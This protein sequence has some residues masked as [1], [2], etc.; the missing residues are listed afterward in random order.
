[1]PRLT[2][3]TCGASIELNPDQLVLVAAETA[4]FAEAHRHETTSEFEGI[5]ARQRRRAPDPN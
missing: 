2:C 5:D 4:T 3:L 1:M